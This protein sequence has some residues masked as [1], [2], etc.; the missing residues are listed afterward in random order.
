MFLQSMKVFVLS[1]AYEDFGNI[2]KLVTET[3][4]SF[5]HTK[6]LIWDWKK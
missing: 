1:R 5:V 4:L 3:E 6:S 2:P